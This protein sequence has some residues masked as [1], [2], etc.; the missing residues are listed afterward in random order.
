[1]STSSDP[2]PAAQESQPLSMLGLVRKFRSVNDTMQNRNFCFIL[3]AGASVTSNIKSAGS[4]VTEWVETLY[5]EATGHPGAVPEG[6]A[7]GTTLR[8]K[9]FDPKDPAGSY[10]ALYRRMYEGD[11]DAGYAYLEE[12]MKNAEPS[13]G[14]SVL[15]RILAETRHKVIITVNFD[16]LV[17]DSVALF[18]KS[19]PLVCGHELL[20]PFVTDK[21]RR[22]LVLKVHRDLLLGPMSTP[23]EIQKIDKGFSDAIGRL[24]RNYTPIVI[25]YG[26]NDGSLMRCLDDLPENSIPGGIYWCYREGSPQPPERIRRVVAKHRGRLVSIMGFDELLMQFG[27]ELG[28]GVPEQYV[29]NRAKERA[30]RIVKQAQELQ[31]RIRKRDEAAMRSSSVPPIPADPAGVPDELDAVTE[32]MSS[33]MRRKDGDKRWWQWNAEANA[34]SDPLKRDDVYQQALKALPDSV[35]LLGNYANFL[36]DVRKDHDAA[37]ALYKRAIEA[38]PK[39]EN[40]LG[41]YAVFLTEIRGSHDAAEAM[42]KR[43]IDADPNDAASLSNYAKFLNDIRKDHDTAETMCKRAIDADPTDANALGAYALFLTDVR[44]NQDAAEAMYKR[45]LDADPKDADNLGNYARFL[46]SAGRLGEGNNALNLA[47]NALKPDKVLQVDIECWMYAYCFRPTAGRHEAL[48]QLKRLMRETDIRTG[49]W[50]F[51]G[52][53][54]QAVQ[55]KHPEAEWLPR[56]AEV[57]AGRAE[58]VTLD[59]WP[60]WQA[61]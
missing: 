51:S 49:D 53:I 57:L 34:E 22:P 32:A 59:A 43:A 58:P 2:Q 35:P 52:V 10:S 42:F 14:Y 36:T 41:N 28:F 9:D 33:T 17:A 30:D 25:G 11:P 24:L 54:K 21:L 45:S 8:I 5:R 47:L 44:K 6:W 40:A 60:A 50:D 46:F 38:Y 4:M 56:L 48:K 20:A 61:A 13:F 39:D 55:L 29:L 7:T 15:G 23:E 37:E 12:Q 19:Y 18:S 26:G 31:E 16:N 3:G 1:M 27:N